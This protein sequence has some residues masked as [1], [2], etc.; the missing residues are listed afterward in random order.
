MRSKHVGAFLGLILAMILSS[1]VIPRQVEA[2]EIPI[3]VNVSPNVLNIQSDGTV[4]SIH[5][6]INYSL[7]VGTSVTVNDVPILFWK[8][9]AQGYFV[10]KF[11]I[12]QIKQLD[13]LKIG[14]YNK[15]T[16]VGYTTQGDTFIGSQEI[17]I[18]DKIPTVK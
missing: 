2:T 3:Q 10:A 16:L 13:G 8:N 11:D 9:D 18:I 7:V 5:T 17:K 6:D 15:L 4:L 1:Y 14:D 12:N